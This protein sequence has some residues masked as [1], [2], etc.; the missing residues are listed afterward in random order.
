MEGSFEDIRHVNFN[1]VGSKFQQNI[2]VYSRRFTK[3]KIRPTRS[4]R[5]SETKA[6]EQFSQECGVKMVQ[7]QTVPGRGRHMHW[8]HEQTHSHI[9]HQFHRF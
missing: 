8:E 1:L 7:A 5:T 6:V 3:M 9:H 2:I 4:S